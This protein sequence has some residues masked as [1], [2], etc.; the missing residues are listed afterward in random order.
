MKNGILISALTL[1]FSLSQ[2]FACDINGKTGFMPENKLNISKDD[3]E[4]NG[5][6]K[7]KFEAI[8]NRVYLAYSPIISAKGA[9]LEM[10]NNWDDGTVNAYA[11]RT[12]STWHVNMFGG[13]ARH[14]L[15]T[16]DGF[17]LVVCHETGHHLGGA[18]KMG[19]IF[20]NNWASN[21]GQAD[22]FGSLK[23]MKRVLEKD[24]NQ[25]IVAKMTIDPDAK[26][27]CEMVYKS[28]DEVALCERIAMAGKSLAQL[29]GDLGG[30]SIVAFNTPDQS[31]VKKTFDAHPQAQCRMDTYF[32]GSLCDKAYSEDVSDKSPIDGTCIKKDGYAVGPRPLCWYKPS[33]SEI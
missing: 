26:S 13:L 16:D 24:D 11:N 29:L 33:A 31:V 19:S 9:T 28:G 25:A 7:E 20:G 27:K 5:M 6:T 18:P 8:V 1:T 12:G 14:P 21:E 32:S 2:A 30:N 3:K 10:D 15:V 17:L 22:Y 4:T 23:C